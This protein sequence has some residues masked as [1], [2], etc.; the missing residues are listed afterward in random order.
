M[1]YYA[2]GATV[3]AATIGVLSLGVVIGVVLLWRGGGRKSSGQ[4]RGGG[5]QDASGFLGQLGDKRP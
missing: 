2:L 5:E 4:R 1:I 3:L